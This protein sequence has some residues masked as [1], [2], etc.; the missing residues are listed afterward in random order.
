MK[1]QTK[2]GTNQY[3]KKVN[4]VSG[5]RY[6]NKCGVLN[7]PIYDKNQPFPAPIYTTNCTNCGATL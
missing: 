2:R 6:C 4:V 5:G 7:L 3:T 1:V